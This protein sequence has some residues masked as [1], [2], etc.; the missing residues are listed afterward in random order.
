MSQKLNQTQTLLYEENLSDD[1]TPVY[2]ISNFSQVDEE[3]SADSFN[4]VQIEASIAQHTEI[5][6][7]IVREALVIVQAVILLTLLYAVMG[8]GYEKV[9]ANK[10]AELIRSRAAVIDSCESAWPA[11]FRRNMQ[12]IQHITLGSV[13]ANSALLIV[14]RKSK[15]ISM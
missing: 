9:G 11:C 12:Y 1:Q 6:L 10:E 13:I 5:I 3:L 15:V 14:G 4:T 8:Q 2:P 7:V